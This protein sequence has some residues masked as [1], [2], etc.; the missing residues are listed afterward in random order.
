[1]VTAW[2]AKFPICSYLILL[3]GHIN[4]S[5]AVNYSEEKTEKKPKCIK[6]TPA[7]LSPE[8]LLSKNNIPRMHTYPRVKSEVIGRA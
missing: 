6:N 7:R 1:M 2:C 8:M 5:F 4:P 3:L